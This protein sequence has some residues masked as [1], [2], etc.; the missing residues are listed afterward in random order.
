MGD[1]RLVLAGLLAVALAGCEA[2]STEARPANAPSRTNADA[3]PTARPEPAS[4]PLQ[5]YEHEADTE[6]Q[7]GLASMLEMSPVVGA[8]IVTLIFRIGY[9][10]GLEEAA[11]VQAYTDGQ[12]STLGCTTGFN[13]NDRSRMSNSQLTRHSRSP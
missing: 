3:E 1:K 5:P 7:N 9:A 12:M 10:T 13:L 6:Y 11:N 4:L 8:R 2:R